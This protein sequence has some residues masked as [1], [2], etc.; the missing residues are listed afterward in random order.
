MMEALNRESPMPLWAQMEA[1][2]R[3][4]IASGEFK[5]RFP[6]DAELV[7][8]YGVSRH[9]A[10]VAIGRLQ[11]AGLVERERGRGSRLPLAAELEQSISPFYSL[12]ASISQQGLAEHSLVRRQELQHNGDAASRLGLPPATE[13]VH[14]QR[15]RFAGGEPLALDDSW[16]V[17]DGGTPLLDADLGRGSLYEMLANLCNVRITG[18]TE[19]IRATLPGAPVRTLLAL[20]RGEAVLLVERVAFS[21]ER[22]IE[23]RHSLV[24][25]DRFAFVASWSRPPPPV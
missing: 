25:G 8:D 22:A 5:D 24:R 9:T 15:L 12:A 10:R 18:G 16:V 4:R 7:R 1:L 6:T 23:Y 13:L 11:A 2:L 21:D 17:A 19:R 3:S 20:P 14:I